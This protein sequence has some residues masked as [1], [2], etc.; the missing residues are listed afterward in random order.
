MTMWIKGAR[1]FAANTV[2]NVE[3]IKGQTEADVTS[4]LCALL[5][6]LAVVESDDGDVLDLVFE[7]NGTT[8]RAAYRTLQGG[9]GALFSTPPTDTRPAK[10][11]KK[12]R[13]GA[14]TRSLRNAL[15]HVRVDPQPGPEC[16]GVRPIVAVKFED[17]DPKA[18]FV[19]DWYATMDAK[20][21]PDAVRLLAEFFA[22]G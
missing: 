19:P 3:A 16:N 18:L 12:Q 14:I 1:D 13:E 15:A 22:T 4:Y 20:R 5:A 6:L 10:K 7:A 17:G 9:L 2:K 21:L 8:Q 11:K